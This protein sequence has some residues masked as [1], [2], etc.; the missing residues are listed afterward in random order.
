MFLTGFFSLRKRSIA[1]AGCCYAF[2]KL[3]AADK[4]KLEE[5][6]T[7]SI[8][9]VRKESKRVKNYSKIEHYKE[10]GGQHNN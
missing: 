10:T 9:S 7:G 4:K 6:K 8:E 2:T 5:Q 1:S 3:P